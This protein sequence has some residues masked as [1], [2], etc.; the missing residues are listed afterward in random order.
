M[1]NEV[2]TPKSFQEKMKERI[3]DSIGDL[4][5]D[6]ELKVLISQGIK[7]VYFT[8]KPGYSYGAKPTPALMHEII[9]ECLG[10]Q[11]Q[12]EVNN[13]IKDNNKEVTEM[14]DQVIKNGIGM[15][16]ISAINMK[17]SGEMMIFQNNLVNNLNR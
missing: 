4:I 3:R 12:A 1:S 15:A 13:W 2:A 6:E 8:E 5:T 10:K 11:V 17:F 14:I 16:L 7:E 9:K